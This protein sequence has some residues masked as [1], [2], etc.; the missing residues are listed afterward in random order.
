MS[1]EQSSVQMVFTDSQVVLSQ[2]VIVCAIKTDQVLP[3]AAWE[4]VSSLAY[5]VQDASNNLDRIL[6]GEYAP[7]PKVRP[8]GGQP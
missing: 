5:A 1:A 8:K 6:H 4:H 3:P 2:G 7:K